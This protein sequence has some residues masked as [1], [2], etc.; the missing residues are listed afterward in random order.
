MGGALHI[1]PLL[2]T[3]YSLIL[4]II[5]AL[6]ELLAKHS[7]K[8][9][10]RYHTR[11]FRFHRDRDSWECPMGIALI[12]AEIDHEREMVLYRAPAYT[13]NNCQIKSRC[14]H[15]NR[16]REIAVPLDP[17]VQSA[18]LRLQRGISLV[19]LILALFILILE[20]LRHAH[21]AEAYVLGAGLFI[22]FV[23]LLKVLSH[24]VSQ[25]PNQLPSHNWGE[26]I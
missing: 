19:L 17:W 26:P 9:A 2:A 12:R 25:A 24:V 10:D 5:G 20:L 4:L 22:V 3:A 6:L 1:E 18:S 11:G 14:T 21:G 7:Q 13:C 16:G 8:R 23:R 15:S